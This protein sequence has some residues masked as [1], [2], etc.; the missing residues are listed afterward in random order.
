ML[1]PVG[2]TGFVAQELWKEVTDDFHSYYPNHGELKP[3]F[4]ILGS[5]RDEKR[6]IDNVIE[7]ISKA[8]GT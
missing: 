4:D 7:I 3:L 5:E 1:I 2:A 8:K 6:L